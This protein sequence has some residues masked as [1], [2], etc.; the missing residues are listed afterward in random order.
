[1]RQRLLH[2]RISF[3]IDKTQTQDT[4]S[5]S[6][7]AIQFQQRLFSRNLALWIRGC[8]LE[9]VIFATRPIKP[10]AID[11]AC[12]GEDK[13]LNSCGK[14]DVRQSQGTI[15]IGRPDSLLV[16][17]PEEG[18]QMND[19][20]DPCNSRSEALGLAQVSHDHL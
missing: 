3:S 15:L 16:S 7:C 8:W 10:W 19:D 12:A 14:G 1:M 6:S 2:M 9:G 5:Q 20:L 17:S 18:C 4:H 13:T 11:V